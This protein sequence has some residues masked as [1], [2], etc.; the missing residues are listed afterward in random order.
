MRGGE[1]EI[2][3][4]MIVGL[5]RSYRFDRSDRLLTPI[6][7]IWP[8]LNIKVSTSNFCRTN[9]KLTTVIKFNYR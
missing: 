7:P 8:E 2:H 4:L 9:L 6:G 3:V 5:N 1:S